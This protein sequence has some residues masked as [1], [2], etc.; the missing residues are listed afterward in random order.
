V[1]GVFGFFSPFPS[2]FPPLFTRFICGGDIT[3]NVQ[4]SL[5]LPFYIMFSRRF[6]IPS[7]LLVDSKKFIC[8]LVL[9]LVFVRKWGIGFG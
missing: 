4:K 7:T 6:P 2:L 3:E 9:A 1:N 5:L 8:F